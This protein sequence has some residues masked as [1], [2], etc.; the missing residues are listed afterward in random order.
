MMASVLDIMSAWYLEMDLEME[1]PRRQNLGEF[2]GC[3]HSWGWEEVV[4]VEVVAVELRGKDDIRGKQAEQ[5]M[6]QSATA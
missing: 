3:R 6:L 1:T 4:R 2:W 5:T